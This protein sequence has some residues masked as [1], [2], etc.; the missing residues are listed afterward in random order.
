MYHHICLQ[1]VAKTH[2]KLQVAWLFYMRFRFFQIQRISLDLSSKPFWNKGFIVLMSQK[3]NFWTLSRLNE[4]AGSWK[5]LQ[6]EFFLTI[7]WFV[8]DTNDTNQCTCPGD[9]SFLKLLHTVHIKSWQNCLSNPSVSIKNYLQANS[10]ITTVWTLHEMY[11]RP[12]LIK[13]W[14]KTI[15]VYHYHGNPVKSPGLENTTSMTF[16]VRFN[17]CFCVSHLLF[18]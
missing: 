2:V 18:C 16:T 1:T 12:V 14:I 15:F 11:G 17:F 7:V 10:S 6:N 8:C 4:M 3:T 13:S 9:V 5:N